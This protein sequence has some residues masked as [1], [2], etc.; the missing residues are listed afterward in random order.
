MLS[1][2]RYTARDVET[3]TYF[4]SFLMEGKAGE[5]YRETCS[6]QGNAL[7]CVF[8]FLNHTLL[9]CFIQ[10]FLFL[11]YTLVFLFDALPYFLLGYIIFVLVPD[12]Y[13][14]YQK[15]CL[16]TDAQK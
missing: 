4:F 6:T 15:F 8:L 1:L 3:A 2:A 11:Y 13:Q 5:R 16:E 10:F 7:L 14:R 12:S 9:M